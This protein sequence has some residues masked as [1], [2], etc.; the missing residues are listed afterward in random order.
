MGSFRGCIRVYCGYNDMHSSVILDWGVDFR[1]LGF[2]GLI[3]LRVC[4]VWG[5][6]GLGAW[7]FYHSGVGRERLGIM[8]DCFTCLCCVKPNLK[9]DY[10][11]LNPK[12]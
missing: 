3:R 11:T 8:V 2:S 7:G 10:Y 4:R 9:N 5:V 1:G 6:E 12:P